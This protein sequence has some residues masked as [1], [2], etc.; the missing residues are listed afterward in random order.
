[1]SRGQLRVYLGAA[2][3]VGKTFKMLDEGHRRAARVTDVVVG[4]VET[5]NRPRTA[6][7]LAGLEVLARKEV[8]YRGATFTEMDVDAVLARK[9]QV[10]LVDELAHTNIPGSAREKR[11]QDVELLLEAGIDVISTV[12]VQHLESVNDVVEAITGIPQR[13][14]VPDS[15]VRAADQ[16]ELVD[17]TPEALRRRMAHGNIYAPEK[18]DAALGNYFRAG[19]L[20][21]LRELALLW[22]ADSVD[23][24]LQR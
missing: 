12:N 2:P 9:P 20:T 13:E 19:N 10:A 14:T 11:W 22:L 5:H 16:V 17:M 6:E 7:L 21:A 4:Y 24:G 3:G 15:V 8:N 18:V 1:M 23:E